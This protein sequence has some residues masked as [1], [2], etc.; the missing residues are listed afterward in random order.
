MLYQKASTLISKR[1]WLCYGNRQKHTAKQCIAYGI[2]SIFDVVPATSL[3][4]NPTMVNPFT[5]IWYTLCSY[6]IYNILG[7]NFKHL[8]PLSVVKS[9]REPKLSKSKPKALAN[10]FQLKGLATLR[11]LNTMKSGMMGYSHLKLRVLD[12]SLPNSKMKL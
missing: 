4:T 7:N 10:C 3:S 1:K 12:Q 8:C 11:G 2:I 9:W 5:D 6:L